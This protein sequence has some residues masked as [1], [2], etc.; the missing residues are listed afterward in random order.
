MK[1]FFTLWLLL[2]CFLVKSAT[3]T[4]A[5]SGNWSS[6]TPNAPWPGGILPNP[7]DD[8]VIS[9]GRTLSVDGNYTCNSITIG[10]SAATSNTLT[11]NSGFT[12]TVSNTIT[13]VPP[14][15]SAN[16]NLLDAGNGFVN[17]NG[18]NSTNSGNN[19][20]VCAISINTG[21]LN[22]NGNISLGATA[23]RN[24]VTFLGT[25]LLRVTGTYIG[26]GTYT[27]TNGTIEYAGT[28]QTLNSA[29]TNYYN[30]SLSNSGTKTASATFTVNGN[31]SVSGT[32]Q[33]D[34][35]S[36]P[37]NIQINGNWQ[38]TSSN[39]DPFIEQTSRVTFGGTL[40]SQ[41]ISTPLTSGET[42]YNATIN[43]S[44]GTS[45]QLSI[46]KNLNIT[47]DIDWTAGAL[48]LSGN[49]LI[50]TGG[51]ATSALS[52]G[53]IMTTVPG[54]SI[55]ITD[56]TDTYTVDFNNFTVGTNTTTGAVSITMTSNSSTWIGSKFYGA[57]N[58]TKTGPSVDDFA[59]GNI[60]YGPSCYFKTTATAARWRM[61]HNNP[62]PD[63]FYNATFD[64]N[65]TNI[66]GATNNNFIVGAN[67]IGN[68]YYGT[69]TIISTTSG[70][71]FV[72]RQ[73][74]TGNNS[75]IFHGP[76]IINV[77][78]TGNVTIG[79]ATSTNTSTVTIENTL[80]LNSL[81]TSVGDIYI[82][83]STG[84]SSVTLTS[85]GQ[86][87]D[88]TI[89]GATNIYFNSINQTNNLPN[90]TISG[91][92]TNST[93]FVANNNSAPTRCVFNGNVSFTSPNINLRGGTFN[94]TNNFQANGA[95]S[96]SSYGGNVF[97]GTTTF[98]NNG[99]GYWYL[100]N[101]VADDFNANVIFNQLSSGALVPCYATNGTFSKN[102]STVGTNSSITFCGG[103]TSGTV[104]IDGNG[105]Q[106]FLGSNSFIP[107]IRNLVMNTTSSGSI[108]LNV[109]L[110][111]SNSL[112]MTSGNIISSST[113]SITLTDETVTSNIGS[114]NSFINGPCYY[115]VTSNTLNSLTFPVGKGTKWRPVILGERNSVT[116]SITYKAEVINA[117]ARSLGYTLPATVDTVSDINYWDVDRT[118]TST[119]AA[120]PTQSLTGTQSITL[121][122]LDGDEVR[123]PSNLRIVKNTSAAP[124]TWIDIGGTGS[125]APAGFITSTSSPS[126]FT[127]YSRF[128]L[129]DAIGGGNP[130]PI[131]LLSFTAIKNNQQVDVKWETATESNNDYYVIERSKDGLNFEK[132]TVVDGAGNSLTHLSY[133]SNDYKPYRGV[134]YYRLKQVDFDG[135]FKYSQIQS[136]E[137]N[138]T[139]DFS[140]EVYPN[141]NDGSE[142]NI[143]F[144]EVVE[145]IIII[146]IH[147]VSGKETYSKMI[148]SNEDMKFTINLTHE[149]AKGVYFITVSSDQ[150]IYRKKLI[151]K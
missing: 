100:G 26:G 47:N 82:G 17:C 106:L 78:L 8:I 90:S 16:T 126:A 67:S 98:I 102:I 121:Y 128:T 64:A 7:G 136:V 99:T 124:T 56:P 53:T 35:T 85:S 129:G 49:N 151:V 92:P 15:T 14:I 59:G 112:L 113:N 57:T 89:L 103:T 138:N 140:F 33:L 19:N 87:I 81:A 29:I 75:H 12:L 39:A 9:G 88:G 130:L 122:Y 69:T 93:I 62:T 5:G 61:G 20:R 94:G 95:S 76:I 120:L 52:N 25:G 27:N 13:I 30:L 37:Y 127:N 147:D 22:V 4:I 101:T 135:T 58:F 45:P 3:I 107:T 114:A 68:E 42:F 51:S 72:G 79:D 11:V 73:N 77:S 142:I 44:F 134:S 48:N 65:G 110:N 54:S 150:N 36:T 28:N 108:T 55:T 96:L 66:A 125:G 43:N 111:I 74:G 6:T 132:V 139:K 18:L 84:Y 105:T 31:L 131:E 144:D 34:M 109:P 133:Y 118:L 63:I 40:N 21:T 41:S 60:F 2:L 46:N 145:N 38:I 10:S 119:G 115:N 97:N 117:S 83:S 71:F 80:Q 148:A 104:T 32:T 23:L 1:I 70:G 86:I 143:A 91:A 149:L 141:P 146:S 50:I 24:S 137:F 116:T 123:D